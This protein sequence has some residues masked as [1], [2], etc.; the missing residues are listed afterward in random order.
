MAVTREPDGIGAWHF[1]RHP[2]TYERT[3]GESFIKIRDGV[4]NAPPPSS[5][6]QKSDL[7]GSLACERNPS[8]CSLLWSPSDGFVNKLHVWCIPH[9]KSPKPR[10]WTFSS[11]VCLRVVSVYIQC[12]HLHRGILLHGLCYHPSDGASISCTS[13]SIFT[14]SNHRSGG[15]TDFLTD[16]HDSFH[17]WYLAH[18]CLMFVP[19][20]GA[21]DLEAPKYGL[22]PEDKRLCPKSIEIRGL[23]LLNR[24]IFI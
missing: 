9:P 15:F 21:A 22:A 18:A 24:L 10:D 19:C 11:V 4:R 17:E 7:R 14:D 20:G 16:G 1:P 12:K 6:S 3:Y 2:L 8:F 5:I 23:R 13:V